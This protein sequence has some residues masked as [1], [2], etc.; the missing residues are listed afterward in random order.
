MP[1]DDK[2]TVAVLGTGTMGLPMARNIAAAGMEVRAWNRTTGRAR[3]LEDDGIRVTEEPAEAADGA[4]VLL[5]M[6]TDADAVLDAAGRALDG[7]QPQV[8]LQMSTIGVDG[9]ERCAARAREH[10]VALVDAPV[11][12]TKQ[13]AEQGRL[14]VLASGPAEALE[15]CRPILDAVGQKVVELGDEP[16]AA[17][18]MKLVVNHWLLGVMETIAQTLQTAE[19]LG[20]DPRAWLTTIEGG[21]LDLP[22]AQL[23]GD[24]ILE[25][26]LDAAFKLALANKDARLLLDAAQETDLDPALLRVVDERQRAAIDRGHGEDDMAATYF[27]APSVKDGAR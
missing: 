18:R 22:Y 14:V 7:A 12:G 5:T 20:V 2:P 11:S 9:M 3:P 21:P 19:A 25:G 27:G 23:K 1:A 26:N 24:A 15:S 17:T 4:D 6:L 16:G 10:D 8:W 13:P